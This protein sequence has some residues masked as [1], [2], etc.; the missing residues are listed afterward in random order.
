MDANRSCRG[1]D[2]K[3]PFE[4]E[5][6]GEEKSVMN[7]KN[8]TEGGVCDCQGLCNIVSKCGRDADRHDIGGGQPQHG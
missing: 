7:W 2:G 5:L 4:R 6:N 3:F 8:E 1:K